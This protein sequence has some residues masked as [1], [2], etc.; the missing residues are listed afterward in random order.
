[1][2]IRISEK[3]LYD[4]EWDRVA[5]ALAGYAAT[6]RGRGR[7]L[8]LPFLPSVSQAGEE[9]GRV[10]EYRDLYGS[11]DAPGLGGVSSAVADLVTAC[12]K[13]GV[14][15]VGELSEVAGTIQASNRVLRSM[16]N[17]KE[18]APLLF[19]LCG[20]LSETKDAL[21]AID[22]AVN[23]DR[24]EIMDRATPG[25]G[26]MRKRVRDLH[27]K[28]RAKLGGMLDNEKIRP[29]LRDSYYTIREDRYVLPVRSHEKAALKGIVHGSSASG[30]T[31]FVEPRELVAVNNDL[32]L[33]QMEVE[34]E[35]RKVLRDLSRRVAEEAPLIL[36]NL[37]ILTR[38]DVVQAKARMAELLDA[39]PPVMTDDPAFRLLQ[40]RHPLLA[41]RDEDVVANDLALGD[42]YHVLVLSG[43]NT[44]GKTVGLKTMGLCVLMAW[45]GM[46]VP[47]L[48]GSTVG[49]FDSLYSVM[50]DE[51]SLSDDLSTFSANIERLNGVLTRCGGRSL[52]LL[53][54]IVVGTDPRQGAALAQAIVEGMADSG[55]RV[56]VT[57]HYERL[58]RLAYA[59]D[60]FMNAAVGLDEERLVPTYRIR[61]GVP[62]SSSAF[63]IATRLGVSEAVVGRANALME[64]TDD[65]IDRMVER[66]EEEIVRQREENE[67]LRAVQADLEIA[68]ATY[69]RR[70]R[71]LE[72][73]EKQDILVRRREL[74]EEIRGSRDRVRELIAEL[75]KGA[76]M[77]R[78]T[79]AMERL[80]E[81]EARAEQK[82]SETLPEPEPEAADE[83]RPPR[84]SLGEADIEPGM[85]VYIA[86]LDQKGV[87]VEAPDRRG[88]A[89]VEVG[90]LKMRMPVER[91]KA[92][93]PGEKRE[94]RNERRTKLKDALLSARKGDGAAERQSISCDLRG[95]RVEE[96]L[97]KV[98]AFLD[99]AMRANAPYVYLI[100]GHGTGRLKEAVRAH[101]GASPY[102]KKFRAGERGEGQDGVTVAFLDEEKEA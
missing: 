37:D 101:L 25:L 50:G 99:R 28:V 12:T 54:E 86:N 95:E 2:T 49:R 23:R 39:Q 65:R 94:N 90:R 45:A 70:L 1:M 72:S 3:T 46:H 31:I 51:Q 97:D 34:R 44:G 6:K 80:R 81:M 77:T 48:P 88:L 83:H 27:D 82:V 66:L 13:D 74:L 21:R 42:G 24:G 93:H 14:L 16:A 10:A 96:A 71:L 7:C 19:D 20:G 52:V 89:L 62:G 85:G 69:E 11:G 91:L 41:L 102:V 76:D 63:L 100:H 60:D 33:A 55:A 38:L 79:E 87:V 32:L 57:T 84:K 43:A 73:R 67:R 56:V 47:A 61:I 92:L 78:A 18:R 17:R 75:Q 59:R 15:D 8:N 53:D 5:D 9:I 68:K 36:S 64:G 58:K 29:M 40:A 35:E 98:D 26:A 4:L 22:H 30:R